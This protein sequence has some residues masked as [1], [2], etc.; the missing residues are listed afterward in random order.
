MNTILC[1][2]YLDTLNIKSYI[3]SSESPNSQLTYIHGFFF[4]MLNEFL[5]LHSNIT[6]NMPYT[7]FSKL[8]YPSG[9]RNNLDQRMRIFNY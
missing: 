2:R 1:P 4:S 8:K 9:H 6:E 5:N 3:R 7:P